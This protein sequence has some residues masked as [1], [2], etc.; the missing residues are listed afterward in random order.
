MKFITLKNKIVEAL[1]F[2]EKATGT[3]GN[4]PI[5]KNILIKASESKISFSATNLEFAITHSFSGKIIENGE[6]T[7]PSNLFSSLARGLTSERVTLELKGKN[8]IVS[9]DN[10]EATLQSQDT[11]D[12]PIIPKIQKEKHKLEISTKLF[13]ETLGGV[14][15]ATQY[16][17]I[18]PEISGVYFYKNNGFF[19]VATD[20][21]RL[22][23]KRL[24]VPQD[25]IEGLKAII[26]VR[27]AEEAMRV[28]SNYNDEP[29][30]VFFDDTQALFK[31][32][33]TEIVT[34]L[35]DGTFP[36]YQPIIPKE[37]KN[38]ATL[39]RSEFLQAIKLVSSFSTKINDVRVSTEDGKKHIE[40][41]AS[42][43]GVGENTYKIPAKLKGGAF[44]ISFNWRF[45]A[46]GLKSFKDEEITLGVNAPDKPA[47]LKS[48]SDK[49][50]L[51]VVMPLKI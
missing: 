39:N 36:D 26:P 5:L 21:F 8:L 35:I 34:R 40:L 30:T 12:F 51:Y 10:Y 22:A 47:L 7:V 28:F 24:V 20:S 27:A 44:S 46:D 32:N 48:I 33:D 18:R 29:L 37:L 45:L 19:L 41:K 25:K 15:A 49:T 38:E 2:V 6:T 23:E 13:S 42:S 9:T 16:S 3:S 17:E 31:T 11:K 50:L 14:I 43:A 1:N 4:L